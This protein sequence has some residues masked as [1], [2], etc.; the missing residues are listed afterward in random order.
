MQLLFSDG[1]L[2]DFGIVLPEQLATFPHGAGRYLWRKLEW[3]AIDLSVSEPAQKPTQEQIEEALFHLYVG[4][5]R[6]HRGEQA[7]AFEEIQGKAAQCVLA[8]LQGD[9]ADTFSPLRRA[10]Q[11]VSSDT[12]KQLMPGYG[13]S[14]QAAEAML[15]LLAKA[16]ELPLYRAVGNLLREIALT[17]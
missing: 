10:E 9:R 16:R 13:Q 15:R 5:L 11:S 6:E 17:E 4:L 12:L 8:F 7:A 2:C 3:E 14:S 1:V